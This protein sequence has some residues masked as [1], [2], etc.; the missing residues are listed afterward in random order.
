M[1]SIYSKEKLVSTQLENRAGRLENKA[2]RL[3]N[4]V[5]RLNIGDSIQ[6]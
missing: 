1:T 5:D 4:T 2:G 6:I 3:E